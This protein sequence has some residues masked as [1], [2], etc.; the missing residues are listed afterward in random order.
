MIQVSD[1]I[2]YL[3]YKGTIVRIYPDN[4]NHYYS[5]EFPNYSVKRYRDNKTGKFV[6]Y[7]YYN[8]IQVTL[9]KDRGPFIKGLK[10]KFYYETF[11]SK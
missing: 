5:V 10:G 7:Q 9:G 11:T 2:E 1:E 6:E 4:E 3:G 8:P